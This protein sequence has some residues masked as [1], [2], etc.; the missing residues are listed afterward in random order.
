M[1]VVWLTGLS[2]AGK[3]TLSRAVASWLQ[4][5][6]FQV[7]LL[8]GDEVRPV[9]SPRAGFTREDRD[10]HV[11]RVAWV[12]SRLAA[13]GVIALVALVSPYREARARAR[14]FAEQAGVPFL[15][16]YVDASLDTVR[17]RDVKG[18]Y[19]ADV[20]NLTGVSDPY[21]P[22][23]HPELTLQTD[24]LPVSVCAAL[25]LRAILDRTAG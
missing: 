22:P 10:E 11:Q 17:A 2:G 14:V 5:Q 16:V 18:L 4:D 20:P 25:L 12:A 23:E 21:E 13:H 9:L 7:E 15:E 6:R 19:A 3:T 8:D 1:T 24:R